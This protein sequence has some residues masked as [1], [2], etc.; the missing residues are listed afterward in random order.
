M[1]IAKLQTRADTIDARKLHN[2]TIPCRMFANASYF[3]DVTAI[4]FVVRMTDEEDE[5]TRI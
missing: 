4:R 5:W 2:F 1:L 3:F